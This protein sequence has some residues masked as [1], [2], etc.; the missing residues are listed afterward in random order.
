MDA[1]DRVLADLIESDRDCAYVTVK[2]KSLETLIEEWFRR[3][4][5]I[6]IFCDLFGRARTRISPSTG[7]ST[8]GHA[9]DPLNLPES[10]LLRLDKLLPASASLV[11]HHRHAVRRQLAARLKQVL[12]PV[13]AEIKVRTTEAMLEGENQLAERLESERQTLQIVISTLDAVV[14]RLMAEELSAAGRSAA[15]NVTPPA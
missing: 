7:I 13:I 12:Y 1:L 3:G 8:E 15:N 5:Q 10:V 6:A 14:N 2:R 4:D 9:H 11:A